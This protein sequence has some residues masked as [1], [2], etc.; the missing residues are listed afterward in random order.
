MYRFVPFSPDHRQFILF[1]YF[2]VYFQ[3]PFTCGSIPP[4]R[5]IS[6]TTL[7]VICQ[8]HDL[9]FVLKFPF[10]LFVVSSV[11]ALNNHGGKTLPCVTPSFILFNISLDPTLIQLCDP[12]YILY[13]GF[14]PIPCKHFHMPFL[15]LP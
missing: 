13:F 1:I 7:Y 9:G 14:S 15:L 10:T 12:F 4:P 2:F 6:P 3:S 5:L 8:N 11:T